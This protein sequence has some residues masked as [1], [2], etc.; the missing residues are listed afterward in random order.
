MK[1][2]ENITDQELQETIRTRTDHLQLTCRAAETNYEI[3]LQNL[4]RYREQNPALK[5]F[6]N[7]QIMIII[8]L[9]QSEGRTKS[10]FLETLYTRDN[11]SINN[12]KELQLTLQ[13]LSHYLHVLRTTDADF[14]EDNISRLYTNYKIEKG[15][16]AE[17]CLEQL[18]QFL[19]AFLNNEKD[20]SCP[21]IERNE[22][23]QYLITLDPLDKIQLLHN[24]DIDTCCILLNLFRERLP[25]SHQI[26]WCSTANEDDIRLF[27]SC[28]RT[29]QDLTFV[30][31]VADKIHH[32]LRELLLN[33][34]NSLAR[35]HEPHGTVYY[36]A[37]GSIMNQKNL[38]SFQIGHTYRNV[39]QTSA[40]LIKLYQQNLNHLQ[41]KLEI[42]CGVA[43]I[44]E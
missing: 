11:V 40:H 12:T 36:V 9:L 24:L 20:I 17:A 34:Q 4:K 33:E 3:W 44:G 23:Q 19:T 22:N 5:L 13:L 27:F 26:L 8:I 32:R 18:S 28:V 37:R 21:N 35:L 29:F 15:A 2:N 42:I 43:G 10:H 30:V 41:P 39:H 1:E 25:S 16:N 31:M 7:R 14:S 38:R 6:S